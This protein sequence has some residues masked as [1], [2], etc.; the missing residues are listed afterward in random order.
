M[1][2]D[3]TDAGRRLADALAAAGVEADLVLAVPRGGLPTA[4][5]VAD[6][7]GAPLDVVVAVKVGAPWNEELALGAVAGDGSRW[8]NDDLVARVGVDDDYL[9]RACEEAAAAARAKVDRYRAGRE[10]EFL[11]ELAGRRVVVVDDGLATGATATACLR[12]VRAAGAAHVTLAV[13][14]GSAESVSALRDE[15]DAVVVPETPRAFTAVGA[16]YDSFGQVSDDEAVALLR[17]A[18]TDEGDGGD[19]GADGRE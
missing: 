13:P 18:G 6:R 14:V 7:L 11:P 16:Y 10:G 9:D 1:F 12:A 3:R 8:L 4:R 2:A 5:V 19:G 15:A 17:A